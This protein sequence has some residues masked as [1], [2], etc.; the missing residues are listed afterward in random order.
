MLKIVGVVP[1]AKPIT[2]HTRFP[3]PGLA[4]SVT[5]IELG[6]PVALP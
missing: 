2:I 5:V 6:D 3:R 1:P 4:G